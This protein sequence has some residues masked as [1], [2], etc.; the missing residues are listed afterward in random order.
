MG[1]VLKKRSATLQ[2]FKIEKAMNLY[3]MTVILVYWITE[4]GAL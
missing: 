3:L 4:I 2:S 1:D